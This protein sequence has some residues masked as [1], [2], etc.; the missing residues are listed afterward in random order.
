MPRSRNA[1]FITSLISSNRTRRLTR[2]AV[3]LG[4]VGALSARVFMYLLDAC[5]RFFLEWLAGYRAPLPPSEGGPLQ[6]VIGP[7]YLWLIPVSTTLGGLIA[8][9]LV[10]TWA[11][12]AEGHGT[13]TVVS[14]F[15]RAAGSIRARVPFV[16]LIASAVTI[17]SGG[18][19]GREG[20]IALIS[21]G[22]G[23]V[24]AKL[25][26]RSEREM[27]YLS[28]VGMAAGLAAIFRSP[29]GTA[30]FAV[31]VLYGGM[32]Y[33]TGALLYTML[34]SVVAYAVNG[35]FVGFEPLFQVPASLATPQT[36]EYP[37]YLLLGI[38]SGL[39]ATL[40]PWVFYTV[41]DLFRALRI[42]PHFKPAI[43]GLG[44]GLVALILPQAIGGGYGWIQLAIDGRLPAALMLWLAF[45]KL[46]T[47]SLTVSSGGSGGVFGPSLY[48]GGML[49]GFLGQI[50]HQPTA[51]FAVVGMAAVFG[52]AA[53]VPI[54]TLLMVTEMTGGY[55]LLVPAA[56]SVTLSY[57]VQVTLSAPLKYESLY[58]AQVPERADSSVHQVEQIGLAFDL[59]NEGAITIPPATGPLELAPL[60][61]TG[62]PLV[63]PD[64][65]R[66]RIGELRPDSS[67]V[68]RLISSGCLT[69]GDSQAELL[70]V[71]RGAEVLTG[72]SNAL[73]RG[74][75]QVV[76]IATEQAWTNLF[77][78]LHPVRPPQ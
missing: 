47:L 6:Q 73:Y 72:G 43:G 19:A 78:H 26:H 30:L 12:E 18:S 2:D 65:R 60:L 5:Q 76:V 68:G 63:V 55:H 70:M 1:Q 66:V 20:P 64:G 49:G 61:S 23:S 48:I 39:A 53:R 69:G 14:A 32:E 41:R 71:L 15:H 67:C 42:A 3:L 56:L 4:V 7:H 74:G 16:K 38:A 59:L 17:G 34:A 28:V 75:D 50:F 57:L 27:R 11:P 25:R 33:E 31:E 36:I 51:A 10:Y 44:V 13:D 54:A 62:L 46:L 52:G 35:L 24:Y 8:G 58:E 21:A 77:A 40:V 29:I 22:V 37:W 9:V 45:G